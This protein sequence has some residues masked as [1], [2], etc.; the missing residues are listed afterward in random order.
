MLTQKK[1][2][3]NLLKI[4]VKI[5]F[6]YASNN[7]NTTL[8]IRYYLILKNKIIKNRLGQHEFAN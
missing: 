5:E 7:L 3:D 1:K 4:V 2:S 8:F 6:A